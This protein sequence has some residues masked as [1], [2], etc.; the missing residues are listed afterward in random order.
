MS[1]GIFTADQIIMMFEPTKESL[2]NTIKGIE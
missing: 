1:L 2:E